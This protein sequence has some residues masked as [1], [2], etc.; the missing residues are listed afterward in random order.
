M[1]SDRRSGFTL[2]ELMVVVSVILIISSIAI[3]VFQSA[4]LSANETAAMGAMRAI[5][6]AQAALVVSPAIDTDSDGAGEYGYFAE[7]AG[8]VPARVAAA[9]VPAAGVVGL[10]E[11]TPSMLISGLGFVSQSVITRS[12]YVFQLWLPD[13]TAGGLV[14]AIPEDAN[15]GK[16]GA[17]FPNPNNNE[18]FWCA[19]A[20]PLGAERTGNV[21]L[22]VNQSGTI[23]QT[24]NRGPAAYEGLAGGPAFDAAFSVPGDMSSD[25]AIGVP[26]NDGN[27]WVTAD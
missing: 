16:L 11:L 9:G 2:I 24:R 1:R 27:L 14:S 13:A 8:T 4:K 12:G 19:Y 25:P 6:S 10:N 3:P 20:W 22:F 5:S 21:A 23:M 18:V 17:P 7:L 15:G 26:A